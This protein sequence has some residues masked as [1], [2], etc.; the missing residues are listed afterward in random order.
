MNHRTSA[1]DELDKVVRYLA[2]DSIGLNDDPLK[3]WQN[4][5][6]SL[7]VLAQLARE[8]LSIPATSV[9]IL[10]CWE[11]YNSKENA[12]ITEFSKQIFV[13][14]EKFGVCRNISATIK[15]VLV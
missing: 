2:L 5:K 9:T 1:S 6:N 10:R 15:F 7:L 11:P 3:W 12:F 8:Y 13:F 14:K 4:H